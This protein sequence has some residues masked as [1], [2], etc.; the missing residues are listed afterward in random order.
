[1]AGISEIILGN[2]AVFGIVRHATCNRNLGNEWDK[3]GRSWA[4]AQTFYQRENN[5]LEA[6]FDAYIMSCEIFPLMLR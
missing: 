1:M 6:Y 4:E 5:M 3:Y 2:S